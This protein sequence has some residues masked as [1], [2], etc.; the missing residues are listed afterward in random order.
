MPIVR[1]MHKDDIF[2]FGQN[3]YKVIKAETMPQHTWN[4]SG[5]AFAATTANKYEISDIEPTPE[6]IIHIETIGID[7]YIEI[8]L[9]FPE[10]TVRGSNKGKTE[11][12]NWK[13]ADFQNPLWYSI[14][15]PH[16][17]KPWFMIYNPKSYVITSSIILTGYIYEIRNI[18]SAL[19]K[20]PVSNKMLDY[21][22]IDA[23]VPAAM[24]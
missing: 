4:N 20:D 2:K 21:Q 5:T 13:I 11:R 3:F 10:A 18:G 7:G 19:P 16:T 17:Y 1:P 9:Y 6:H 15:I 24:V 8:Q 22:S 23:Y 12:F 14:F